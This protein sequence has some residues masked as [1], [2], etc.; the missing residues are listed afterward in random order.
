MGLGCRRQ[1]IA[2]SAIKDLVLKG[3]I[4]GDLKAKADAVLPAVLP[5]NVVPLRREEQDGLA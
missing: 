3:K 5:D 2:A 1:S 4:S